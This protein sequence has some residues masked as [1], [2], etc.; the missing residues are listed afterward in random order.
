MNGLIQDKANISGEITTGEITGN[1]RANGVLG[2]VV[3]GIVVKKGL[4]EFEEGTEN[5]TFLVKPEGEE[6]YA[7]SIH[8]LK[9]V[10]FSGDVNDLTQTSVLLLDC[11]TST[12]NV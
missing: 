10:A 3:S 5:G 9:A 8:G 7:V 12:T 1:V 2:D 4:Y 11:G 6:P